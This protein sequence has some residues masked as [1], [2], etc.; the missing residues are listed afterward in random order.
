[1]VQSS[2]SASLLRKALSGNA[3]FSVSSALLFWFSAPQVALALGL[4]NPI[5]VRGLALGL[6]GFALLIGYMLRH[7]SIPQRWVKW[8]IGSDLAWVLGSILLLWTKVLTPTA[9]G[10]W[11]VVGVAMVVAL[12]AGLQVLGLK[13]RGAK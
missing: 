3:L 1:M 4:T 8:I 9:V 12:F 7:K 10:W 13:S 5:W 11:G 2:S 6:L